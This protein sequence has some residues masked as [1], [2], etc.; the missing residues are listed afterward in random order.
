MPVGYEIIDKTQWV[1]DAKTGKDKR[2]SSVTKQERFRR[3]IA[4]SITNQL[5]FSYIL[6]DSWFC[7]VDN[8]N[9]MN[10]IQRLLSMPLKSNRK[11][12]LSQ[13]DKA[14][15]KYQVIESLDIKENQVLKVYVDGVD[16]PYPTQL[17]LGADY[18]HFK[19]NKQ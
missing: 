1:K 16:F 5:T 11:V 9:L 4:Q 19:I 15:G 13:A 10:N 18:E 2:I 12:A 3:L 7:S 17:F 14:K 8:I 6:A